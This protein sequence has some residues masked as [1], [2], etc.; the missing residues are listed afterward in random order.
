MQTEGAG[1]IFKHRYPDSTVGFYKFA[2]FGTSHCVFNAVLSSKH[3]ASVCMNLHTMIF[4]TEEE[5]ITNWSQ[6]EQPY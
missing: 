3:G 2:Q 4:T 5:R 6:T 1:W